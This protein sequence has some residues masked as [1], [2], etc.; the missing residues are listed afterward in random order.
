MRTPQ[1]DNRFYQAFIAVDNQAAIERLKECG[2][3][4]NGKFD[5]FVT[6]QIPAKAFDG[7]ST[8]DGLGLISLSRPLELCNDSARYLSGVDPVHAA[9]HLAVPLTGEGGIVGVVD[10]GIDFNHIN[11]CDAEGKS[12][13]RAVY[14]PCDST[15][16][17]PIVDDEQL[18]GSCYESASKIADLTTDFTHSSHGTHTTGTAAGGYLGNSFYGVATGA[19]IVVCGMPESELTDVNITNSVKYIFDYADRQGKPCV[20]N[21]SISSHDGPNDGTSF[22]CRAFE[23]LSSPGHICVVSAGNE[24]DVPIHFKHTLAG[25]GDTVTTLLRNQWGGLQREGYVSMWSDRAQEHRSRV[26]VIN[27]AT[28]ELEYAS[29]LIG[30]L[31]EDS[32]FTLSDVTDSGFAAYY[33]GEMLF[34]N[35][36][37]PQY[38]DNGTLLDSYRYHSIWL[39]DATSVKSGHLLGLQYVTDEET[40]L[41]GWCNKN[42]YFYTFG[43]EGITGGTSVGSISDMATTD[44]VISVGAY[45]SRRTVVNSDGD[46]TTNS[47]C[48]PADIAYFSSYGPDE[49]GIMRPDVCAPGFSLISSANRY[50]ESA[51]RQNWCPV[52]VVDGEEYPYYPNMGTSMSAPVVTGAIALMLQVNPSFTAVDVR[53][54]LSASCVKDS[55]VLNGDPARWGYGKLDVMAAI[56]EVVDRT[57]LPGDVNGDKEVNVTDILTL[58]DM[59]LSDQGHHNAIAMLRADVNRDREILF[60]DINV[61][62]D[63]IL[64]H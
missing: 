32:V 19:D 30:L 38:D 51:N 3:I 10:V 12:R 49:R 1:L 58:V 8:I 52:A 5:G 43:L 35:A 29:P 47:L 18:P 17:H 39:F 9:S 24:G 6:A 42:T 15:G 16:V 61:V 4:V 57:L 60:S 54:I 21:M 25:A 44:D 28:R 7:L 2:I 55:C 34:A 53:N 64:K 37:E 33:Q 46:S 63:L 22:L 62:I 31:P 14:M 23:S 11:L 45:G 13:V 56:D 36:L 27:R 26:V 40:D 59:I 41:A 50:N 48:I 20:V